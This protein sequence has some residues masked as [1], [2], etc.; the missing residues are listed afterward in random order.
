[1][2]WP[3]HRRRCAQPSDEAA[4]AIQQAQ[5][6]MKDTDRMACRVD[7][8]ADQLAEIHRRNH[9]GAAVTRAIRGV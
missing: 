4:H 2:R 5:R 6:Q 3:F 9:I 1:M 7:E 8:V